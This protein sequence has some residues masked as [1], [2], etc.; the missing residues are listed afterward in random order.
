MRTCCPECDAAIEFD[1]STA[2]I[3][4]CPSC[5]TRL[6]MSDDELLTET[7]SFQPDGRMMVGHFEVVRKVGSGSFGDVF[8]ARD[9]QLERMVAIKLLRRGVVDERSRA[10]FL[11]E[12]RAAARLK[13]PHIVTV[14]GLGSDGDT[15]YIISD[16]IEGVPLSKYLQSKRFEPREAAELCAF[17]AEALAHAHQ[18]GVVHRDLKPSN[19]MLDGHRRPHVMDF[20]LAKREAGDASL[21]VEGQ[22]LGTVPYMPPEQ[23]SG[24]AHLADRRSDIYSLGVVLYEL[25]TGSCPF[26]GSTESIIY[27]ILNDEPLP[28]RK[29]NPAV[30]HDLQ[31]ICLKALAKSPADRYATAEDIAADLRHFLA[32]EPIKARRSGRVERAWRWA[33]RKPVLAGAYAATIVAVLALGLAARVYSLLPKTP[34]LLVGITT[35]P[36]GARGV[37]VS[38]DPETGEPN[39][40]NK[41]RFATT[42]AR[43]RLPAGEYL[44]VVKKEGFGFH[45]VYRTVPKSADDAGGTHPHNYWTKL[46]IAEIDL[47]K[48]RIPADTT[49]VSGMTPF[50]GGRFR[51]G[52][53]RLQGVPEH[54]R[55]MAPFWLDVTEV[56]VAEYSASHQASGVQNQMSATP[57]PDDPIVFRT[58]DEA[59][60]FAEESGKRLPTEFEYEFAA[61]RGGATEFPWG[62]RADK[63]ENWQFGPVRST[64]I[65]VLPSEPPVFGLYSNVAEWTESKMTSY[66]GAVSFSPQHKER[67]A[68]LRVVRGIDNRAL[69]TAPAQFPGGDWPGPRARLGLYPDLQSRGV[70]FRCARSQL[71]RFLD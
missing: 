53:N 27:Q 60:A 32:G 54:E 50:N 12:G 8:L 40:T 4:T 49:I 39:P 30:P 36:P 68:L 7:V 69:Q 43:V 37:F 70:G 25:L 55:I 51:V 2:A 26:R 47:P 57:A 45:E 44:V 42:P 61:T 56:T 21:A 29:A 35:D 24:K 20:G 9:T 33:K 17:I 65:D 63:M 41:V 71:P 34:R 5:G 52:S 31:I 22:L 16:F 11:R 23:A 66:P 48:I 28:P 13:H 19:I 10:M 62:N 1:D 3:L 59:R 6:G 14:H 64:S 46:S 15:Y 18:A 58:F 38:L 67:A